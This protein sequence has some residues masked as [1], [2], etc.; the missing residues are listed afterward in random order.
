VNVRTLRWPELGIAAII[1]FFSIR[2]LGTFPASWA[3]EGL[4]IIVAKMVATG[5]GYALPLLDQVWSYPYFLNVG[6]ALI[7]PSAA[8]IG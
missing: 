6:P 3:D 5:Q 8:S 7:Y 1:A 4:F 2:E